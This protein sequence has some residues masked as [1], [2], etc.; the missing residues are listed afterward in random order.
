MLQKRLERSRFAELALIIEG[1]EL[2]R[3]SQA[4]AGCRRPG[5]ARQ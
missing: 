5:A 3:L 4:L 2:V 1:C